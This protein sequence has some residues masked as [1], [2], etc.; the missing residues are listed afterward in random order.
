MHPKEYERYVALEEDEKS[1]LFAER[2]EYLALKSTTFLQADFN[3]IILNFMIGGMHGPC[4]LEDPSF[5]TLAN[6]KPLQHSNVAIFSHL[7]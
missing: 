7:R 6:G 2:N 4:L 1:Q 3:R 5:A